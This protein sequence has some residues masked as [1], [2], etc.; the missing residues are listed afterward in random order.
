MTLIDLELNKRKEVQ[1]PTCGKPLVFEV[2]ADGQTRFLGCGRDCFDVYHIP[3]GS[4]SFGMGDMLFVY[5]P[6]HA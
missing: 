2:L 3:D 6:A 5:G 1:C 4:I